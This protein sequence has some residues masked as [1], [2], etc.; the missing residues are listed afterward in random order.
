ERPSSK[1]STF[2]CLKFFPHYDHAWLVAKDIFNLQKHQIEVF[3]NE[4]PKKTG[5]LYNGFRMALD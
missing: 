2:Y 1:K 3:I 5:D 4:H